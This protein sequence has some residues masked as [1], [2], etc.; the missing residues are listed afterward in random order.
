VSRKRTFKEKHLQQQVEGIQERWDEGKE[1]GNAR[2]ENF[3]DLIV[4]PWFLF[5]K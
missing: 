2:G 4:T 1:L 5:G 3:V